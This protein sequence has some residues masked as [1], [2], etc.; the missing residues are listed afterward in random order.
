MLACMCA[1]GSKTTLMFVICRE[2]LEYRLIDVNSR[3]VQQSQFHSLPKPSYIARRGHNLSVDIQIFADWAYKFIKVMTHKTENGQ[4][5]LLMYDGYRSN[6]ALR[7]L[8]ILKNGGVMAYC[9]PGHTSKKTQP[10]GLGL[11]GLF[12]NYLNTELHRAQQSR[13]DAQFDEFDLLH[14]ICQ[15]CK[16]A[17]V[18]HNTIKDFRTAGLWPLNTVRLLSTARSKSANRTGRHG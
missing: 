16:R 6:I 9:L 4:K 18:A 10:L 14:M 17:F 3:W 7:T 2:N 12:K 11:Y 5:R 15:A 1:D 13:W 8:R